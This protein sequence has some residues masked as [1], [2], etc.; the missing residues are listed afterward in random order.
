MAFSED[1]KK[2]LDVRLNESNALSALREAQQAHIHGTLPH[3]APAP[4]PA[5]VPEPASGN[6]SADSGNTAAAVPLA[7]SG[8]L[9]SVPDEADAAALPDTRSV[10]RR[11]FDRVLNALS[12]VV[13]KRGDPPLEIVRKCVFVVA[14]ITLIGSLSYIF[15]DMVISP[16][17]NR[18]VTNAVSSLYNPDNPVTPPADFND[19]PNGIL[20]TFKA[21]YANNQDVRGWVTYKSS[22]SDWLNISY[23]V[24]YSGDNS[25]YLTHDFQK[26]KNSNGEPFFDY[27]NKIDSAGSQNKALIIYG[28]NMGSEQMFA[29]LNRML[30]SINYARSAPVINLDTLYEKGDEYKVFAVMLLN[31]K[32]SDGQR[33][34]YLRTDFSSDKDFMDYV[35]NIRA[36]SLYD[37]ND[38]DVQP[39]DQLLV[40]STCSQPSIAK[41]ED[42]RCAVVARKVRSGESVAVD[43][44]SIL[45]N[46]DVIMPEAWYKNQGKDDHP[47]YSGNFTVPGLW[48]DNS[49]TTSTAAVQETGTGAQSVDGPVVTTA[50]TTKKTQASNTTVAGEQ[51][52]HE[53]S[54]ETEAPTAPETTKQPETTAKPEEPTTAPETTKAPETTAPPPETTAAG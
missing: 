11:L 15:N 5:S 14:L 1:K 40:L 18:Y 27:R 8:R 26:A 32:D 45:A 53:T 2:L 17:H 33:F 47:Y 10:P 48:P 4:K 36:R 37:Y 42:S 12:G 38:V 29:K 9:P 6:L 54:V 50:P 34:D 19:Y 46:D 43:T 49:G 3:A 44:S 22:T 51:P 52:T 7:P 16:I 39:D 41:F 21:L 25:Y 28:H 13:P 24:M 35:A 20:D 23:P 30:T 31:N